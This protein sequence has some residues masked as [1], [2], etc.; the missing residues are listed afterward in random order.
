MTA[1][2]EARRLA[3]DLITQPDASYPIAASDGGLC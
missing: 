3:K 1:A 2:E